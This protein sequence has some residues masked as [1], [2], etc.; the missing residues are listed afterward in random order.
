[1]AFLYYLVLLICVIVIT[2]GL[3]L[4]VHLAYKKGFNDGLNINKDI[5]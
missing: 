2:L 1:M 3:L 5:K 4:V